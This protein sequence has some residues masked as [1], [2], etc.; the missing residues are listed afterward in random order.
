M[1]QVVENAHV[2]LPSASCATVTVFVKIVFVWF[3]DKA[4][5]KVKLYEVPLMVKVPDLDAVLLMV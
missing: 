3:P 1:P 4:A 5:L 2:L